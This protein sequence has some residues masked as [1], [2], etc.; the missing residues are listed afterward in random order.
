MFI[1]DMSLLGK[2]IIETF[3]DQ[4]ELEIKGDLLKNMLDKL[5][6]TEQV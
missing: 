6:V 1:Y 3:Y 2:Q 5:E 4:H